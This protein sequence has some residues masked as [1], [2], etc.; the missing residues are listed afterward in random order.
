MCFTNLTPVSGAP[1]N[2]KQS[3]LT[4][5]KS[6]LARFS[7]LREQLVN[8]NKPASPVNADWM[9]NDYDIIANIPFNEIA[10]IGSHN[11]GTYTFDKSAMPTGDCHQRVLSL[12]TYPFI[13]KAI[14]LWSKVRFFFLSF[15]RNF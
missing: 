11:S 4:E 3:S 5:K 9:K 15:Q 12:S 13:S 7:G 10:M 6:L 1:E 8:M 2:E 14:D